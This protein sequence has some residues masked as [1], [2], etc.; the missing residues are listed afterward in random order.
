MF[1]ALAGTT[2]IVVPGFDTLPNLPVHILPADIA[3]FN[4]MLARLGITRLNFAR[5]ACPQHN[6]QAIISAGAD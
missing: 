3:A 5:P 2:Q 6:R 4:A 1:D